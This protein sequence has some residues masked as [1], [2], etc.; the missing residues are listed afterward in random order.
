MLKG[1]KNGQ[2]KSKKRISNKKG[3][4]KKLPEKSTLLAKW[5][6]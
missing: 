1:V 6:E 4:L 2:H 3:F 5:S